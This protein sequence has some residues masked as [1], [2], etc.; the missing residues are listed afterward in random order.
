MGNTSWTPIVILCGVLK[1]GGGGI[2][3][4]PIP[5]LVAKGVIAP[6]SPMRKCK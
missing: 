1:G 5:D 3:Q 2:V 6:P 4:F